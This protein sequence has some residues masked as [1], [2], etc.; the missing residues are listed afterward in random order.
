MG[1]KNQSELDKMELLR[2]EFWNRMREIFKE[3]GTA[4]QLGDTDYG[5]WLNCKT[6][7]KQ[8]LITVYLYP[9]RD[10]YRIMASLD[11]RNA[12]I[13]YSN[14]WEQY[15]LERKPMIDAKIGFPVDRLPKSGKAQMLI[16]SEFKMYPL[17]H[18]QHWDAVIKVMLDQLQRCQNAFE[19]H[20]EAFAETHGYLLHDGSVTHHL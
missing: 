11:G 7:V 20:M 16:G 18:D 15:M 1:K 12:N 9:K 5:E 10:T 14:R 6:S 8:N 3:N 2:Q 17:N 19:P 13:P 4:L